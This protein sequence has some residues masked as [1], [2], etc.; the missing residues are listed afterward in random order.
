MTTRLT[1]GMVGALALALAGPDALTARA[2]DAAEDGRDD[3]RHEVQDDR[4]PGTVPGFGYGSPPAGG[5]DWGERRNFVPPPSVAPPPIRPPQPGP[6]DDLLQKH[7]LGSL[8]PPVYPADPPRHRER[9]PYRYHRPGTSYYPYYPF[10]P[11][12]LSPCQQ[13]VSEKLRYHL[14]PGNMSFSGSPYQGIV[15]LNGRSFNYRCTP[16][17]VNVW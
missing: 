12:T 13:S 4:Y 15:T 8:V 1:A 5:S 16:G 2:A 14:G 10:P 11:V 6:F 17:Q 3:L 9:D 7:G